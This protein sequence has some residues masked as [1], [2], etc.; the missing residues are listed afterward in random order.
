MKII[1][2]THCHTVA[3]T[4]A[5]STIMENINEAAKQNL[6]AIAI[7]DH[8]RNMPSPPG[9]WYFENL[10]I[11]P[12]NINGVNILIGIEANILN[13]SGEIDMPFIDKDGFRFDWVVASVH[14]VAFSGKTDID[15]CT[16]TWLNV[17]KNPVVNV[18]G[19]SGIADFVY[20]YEK[21]IPEFGRNGK[22]VEI[23]NSS[24]VIRPDSFQNCRKIAKLCK[25]HGVNVVVNSDSHFCTQVGRLEK[26]IKFLEEID[27]PE[28]LV[29]N[30]DV[31]RFKSYLEQYTC[32]FEN[33]YN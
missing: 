19:H 31:D 1:A 17:A 12:K 20:D 21:V 13:T 22:L 9:T 28:E 15:S 11:L 7:T 18:I 2:D 29:I 30:A 10:H 25:K 24:F 16:E 6:Y 8:G 3:S 14:D 26:S 33:A 4:H 5:Y 23:N 27:F 32:F